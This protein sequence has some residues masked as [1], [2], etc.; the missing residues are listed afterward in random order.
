MK[1]GYQLWHR[2][3]GLV[4]AV[5]LAVVGCTAPEGAPCD[6]EEDCFDNEIC[7]EGFCQPTSG[8]GPESNGSN[9]ETDTDSDSDTGDGSNDEGDTG[10]SNEPECLGDSA[11]C[12]TV[13]HDEPTSSSRYLVGDSMGCQHGNTNFEAAEHETDETFSLCRAETHYYKLRMY[14][15]DEHPVKAIIEF[16]PESTCPDPYLDLG[17]SIVSDVSISCGEQEGLFSL[18]CEW[19][20]DVGRIEAYFPEPPDDH[21]TEINFE[22]EDLG[23]DEIV[24]DY[25]VE[26]RVETWES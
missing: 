25:S 1:I 3:I 11:Q 18:E 16:H 20:L 6:D 13:D 12:G 8:D 15:C 23:V 7:D 14:A 5:A 10:S 26:V 24:L 19:D 9:G 4:V 21:E 17:A 22:I 2:G